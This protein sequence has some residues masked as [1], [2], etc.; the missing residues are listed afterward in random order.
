MRT[1]RLHGISIDAVRDIF[2]A[3][4]E[5]ATRLRDIAAQRFFPPAREPAGLLGKLGPLFKRAPHTEVDPRAPLAADIDALLAGEFIPPERLVPSW[6]AFSV[7][8]DELAHASTTLTVDAVDDV[9]FDLARNGLS[10]EFS[11]RRLAEREV[12]VPL[13]PLP[14]Q[15]FGYSRHLQAVETRSALEAMQAHPQD[16][17]SLEPATLAVIGR[18]LQ[19]LGAVVGAGEE[20]EVVAFTVDEFT[21]A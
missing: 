2:G 11:L 8:L 16:Q 10:S 9:E 17:T 6:Q 4:D 14:G 18:L 3:G 7:W 19:F 13:R 15:L 12:G 21:E 5:L 1:L 20:V